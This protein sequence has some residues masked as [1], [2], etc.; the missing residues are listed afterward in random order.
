MNK[1]IKKISSHKKNILTIF[2]GQTFAALGTLVGVRLLTE[3]ISPALFGEYK[4]LLA[5][6]SLASG[7]LIRPF[8]QF[9]MREYHDADKQGLLLQFIASTRTI[10]RYYILL[11][12]LSAGILI[13]S[14]L[15]FSMSL[16]YLA[17]FMILGTF[18]LRNSIEFERALSVTGNKQTQASIVSVAR[19][20]LPPIAI[21]TT[22]IL[23]HNESVY[24]MFSSTAAVLAIIYFIQL[25]I[26]FTTT[27]IKYTPSSTAN[28]MTIARSAFRFGAPLASVGLLSWLVHESD[29]F[30]LAYYHSDRVVGLYSA[31]YGLVSAPFTLVA[32]SIAQFLYPIMF[33]VSAENDHKKRLNIMKAMLITTSVISLLGVILVGLFDE[34]IAWIALGKNYREEATHLLLWIALGYS[35]IAISFSFDL[36]AYGS[37]RT[38]DMSISYGISAMINVVLNIILIPDYG[39]MGAVI[40]TLISLFCY[41]LVIA[42]LFFYKEKQTMLNKTTAT[43][44]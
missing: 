40:A 38:L 2:A 14:F 7:I 44:D 4:L 25:S 36:A 37:K 17:I 18:A 3:F 34:Q 6:I 1:I 31:A 39:A 28:Y 15:Y 13:A 23:T 35:F 24:T 5:G 16:S 12:L 32:G 41:L 30:F 33:R 43:I 26:N 9:S 19:N 10:L 8:I 29:R 11:I 42:V 22:V 21:I 20:W 27:P